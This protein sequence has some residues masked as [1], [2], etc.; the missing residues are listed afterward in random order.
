MFAREGSLDAMIIPNC[1]YTS[2]G[3]GDQ[4]ACCNTSEIG[5]SSQVTM[6]LSTAVDKIDKRPKRPD[7]R[8]G[9]R[10]RCFL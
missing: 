1:A 8:R 3:Y 2:H 5:Q 6:N 9:P 7:A 4:S 10:E